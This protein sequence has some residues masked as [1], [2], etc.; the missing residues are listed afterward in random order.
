MYLRIVVS[1]WFV[2]AFSWI[3]IARSEVKAPVSITD[4]SC[5]LKMEFNGH[6]TRYPTAIFAKIFTK[7]PGKFLKFVYWREPLNQPS[8]FPFEPMGFAILI[9]DSAITR[10]QLLS[11]GNWKAGVTVDEPGG[12]QFN[13]MEMPT[14]ASLDSVLQNILSLDLADY[15]REE[16]PGGIR[17]THQHGGNVFWRHK[18]SE[19]RCQFASDTGC[20]ERADYYD[21]NNR[22]VCELKAS[23]P[24]QL[25]G[26]R[27]VPTE[28]VMT[29]KE[30]Q[31]LAYNSDLT[32]S[33]YSEGYFKEKRAEGTVAYPPG[34]LVIH[35]NFEIFDDAVLLPSETK[36]Y[37]GKHE[38]I[39]RSIFSNYRIN[40]GID[41]DVFDEQ[42]LLAGAGISGV[43]GEWLRAK[44][45][46]AHAQRAGKEASTY[47]HI[48]PVVESVAS[49]DDAAMSIEA[50]H[51]L[52]ESLIE[53][54]K[55]TEAIKSI[56]TL[57]E[58][59]ASTEGYGDLSAAVSASGFATQFIKHG[60]MDLA[61]NILDK[62]VQYF[63]Q[64]C[65]KKK[66]DLFQ[67]ALEDFRSRYFHGI[68]LFEYISQHTT[69]VEV[70][71]RCQFAV[72]CCFDMI[73]R[74]SIDTSTWYKTDAEKKR[75]V[76][77]ALEHYGAL[78]ATY[79]ESRYAEWASHFSGI[80]A[81][82]PL[83]TGEP[84]QNATAPSELIEQQASE[85]MFDVLEIL[86]TQRPQWGDAL[87]DTYAKNVQSAYEGTLYRVLTDAEYGN[88]RNSFSAYCERALPEQLNNVDELAIELIT[89]R[90]AVRQYVSR[91]DL[92]SEQTEAAVNR[93]GELIIE[94][95]D[96]FVDTYL[97]DK[98]LESKIAAV[99]KEFRE[100]VDLYQKNVLY[101]I[102]K[103][104]LSPRELWCYEESLLHQEKRM[105]MRLKAHT[106]TAERVAK[107]GADK[108][109]NHQ[110]NQLI[111][112][113]KRDGIQSIIK[114]WVGTIGRA[115]NTIFPDE[116]HPEDPTKK[117]VIQYHYLP[118]KGIKLTFLVDKEDY[119]KLGLD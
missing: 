73:A 97:Y 23:K 89:I 58:Q 84:P 7:Y 111:I 31:R 9:N 101:P 116:F 16:L 65:A 14:I 37:T 77:Q 81:V 55:Y 103:A 63:V 43:K 24:V 102:F 35:R 70:K 45:A 12:V 67:D 98:S 113:Q 119:P 99:K 15:S 42:Y 92:A 50:R 94:G 22:L 115:Y 49:A 52:I 100:A 68:R 13:V 76:T 57:L 40:T 95:F 71:A 29:I 66:Q 5:D 20:L 107:A 10:Y 32:V 109:M 93:Q 72:A 47:A 78:I 83:K 34:G 26:N 28:I 61:Q 114:I 36:F 48:L 96:Q 25:H 59:V 53:Q 117:R 27:W 46:L 19:I 11:N 80:L 51:L 87:I 3:G 33:V 64:Y 74:E 79:P 30:G 18:I 21:I 106:D 85:I 112:S 75:A 62:Y 39:A 41:D 54:K 6:Y 88:F 105:E 86:R 4:L 108:A 1:A 69:E 8:I 56:M 90:W 60:Q 44:I 110:F 17:L 38:L 104:P 2:I 91:L 118:N 82:Y